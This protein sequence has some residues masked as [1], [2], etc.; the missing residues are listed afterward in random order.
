VKPTLQDWE[1]P[2]V[3]DINQQ[4]PRCNFIPYADG[5]E[6]A[7]QSKESPWYQTLSGAWKFNW[8]PTAVDGVGQ[9]HKQDFND[10]KWDSI[11]VPSNVEMLGYGFPIYVNKQYPFPKNPPHIPH[12]LNSISCYRKEFMVPESWSQSPVYLHF[13][14]VNAAA[15]Y[16]INGI[17]LGYSQGS[18]TPVEFEITDYLN[19]EVNTLAV[20]V[21]RWCDGSYL[22]AQDC[23]RLSGIEREVYLWSAPEVHIRDFFARTELGQDNTVGELELE[24]ELASFQPRLHTNL[25]LCLQLEDPDGNIV[26]NTTKE[27]SSSKVLFKEHISNLKAWTAETPHL[28]QLTLQIEGV[29]STNDC[30]VGCK[31]GF[32]CISIQQG[33]LM[34]NGKPIVI[35]G[36]NRH[37]H[38]DTTG[39]VISEESMVRDIELMKQNNIWVITLTMHVGMS[40]AIS[41]D[42][43]WLTR[44]ISSHILW[45]YAFKMTYL[46]MRP[47]I[48]PI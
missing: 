37:E 42:Y 14:A 33:Q 29:C 10:Y 21:Y 17:P 31:L 16:W 28:Y 48:C 8:L 36:V 9:F 3:Y 2:L 24:V 27:I 34:V 4:A 30:L 13:G 5:K 18:K 45:E 19:S 23:W 20:A 46:M 6:L 38:D 7:N 22:E 47:L 39:H 40:Y 12:D 32:R 43:T 35:K 11:Q 1:N 25:Q 26:L 44:L 15:H 41:T